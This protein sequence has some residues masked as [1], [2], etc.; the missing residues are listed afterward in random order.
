[1]VVP[2]IFTQIIAGQLPSFKVAEDE[3]F[4]AFLDI[5]P[6]MPGH[7]LVVPKQE[8]D[9]FFDMDD[10]LMQEIGLFAKPVARALREITGCVRVAAVVAGFDVPHAHLHLIPA[11]TMADL[12]FSKAQFASPDDLR[13]MAGKIRQVL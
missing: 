1:M 7:T 10:G 3:R 2:S 4:I 8:F 5:R 6:V 9:Y 12:D 11:F 13:E